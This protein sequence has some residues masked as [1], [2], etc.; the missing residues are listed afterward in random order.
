[1]QEI[2]SS[3][4]FNTS[5]ETLFSAWSHPEQLSKW[6]GPKG[7]TNTFEIFEFRVG[8]TWKFIMHGPDKGHY[9]NEVIFKEIIPNQLI[10]WD[11]VSQ[12]LFRVVAEFSATEDGKSRLVF[13]MQFENEKEYNTIVKFAPE[14]N[15]ENFDKLEA[16]IIG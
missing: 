7:F 8:G 14:K 1:M 9:H 4:T 2:I 6:W 12:P 15:E 16:L 5:V 3:R 10:V 11:R 13:H